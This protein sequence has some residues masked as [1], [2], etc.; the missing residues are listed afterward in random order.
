VDLNKKAPLEDSKGLKMV[1]G[2]L[3]LSPLNCHRNYSIVS[4]RQ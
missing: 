3:G 2:F 1:F 4:E